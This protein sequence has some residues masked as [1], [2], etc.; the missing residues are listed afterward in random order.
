[1][2]FLDTNSIVY[3]LH[4]VKPYAIKMEGILL[5][6]ADLAISLRILDEILFTSILM[7]AWRKPDILDTAIMVS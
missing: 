2:T 6:E 5:R 3:Y 4:K 1:M 7:E